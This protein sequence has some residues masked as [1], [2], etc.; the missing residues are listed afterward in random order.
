MPTSEK[1]NVSYNGPFLCAVCYVYCLFI[2]H[3]YILSPNLW[4]LEGENNGGLSRFGLGI[5]VVGI[6]SLGVDCCS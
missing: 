1:E 3:R 6:R 4:Q 5:G 2:V